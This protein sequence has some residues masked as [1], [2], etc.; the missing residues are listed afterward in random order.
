MFWLHWV[1]DVDHRLIVAVP[2]LLTVVASPV[3]GHRL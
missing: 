2:C 1:F 3:V